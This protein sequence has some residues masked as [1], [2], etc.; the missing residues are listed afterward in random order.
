MNILLESTMN[1]VAML[2]NKVKGLS[3]TNK[4]NEVLPATVEPPTAVILPPAAETQ[5]KISS[6]N[7]DEDVTMDDQTSNSKDADLQDGWNQVIY[8]NSRP[9]TKTRLRKVKAD[10]NNP[11]DNKY[12]LLREEVLSGDDSAEDYPAL[13]LKREKRILKPKV[14][15]IMTNKNLNGDSNKGNSEN[16]GCNAENVTNTVKNH[17]SGRNPPITAYGLNQKNLR[18]EMVKLGTL[19]YRVAGGPNNNRCSIIAHDT[20]TYNNII[21]L[22][23]NDNT[24]F[25]CFTPK[26]ER[27]LNLIIKDVS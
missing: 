25:F 6:P 17:K 22:L 21:K 19:N 14:S 1:V 13:G 4:A 7:V 16:V 12:I 9:N 27:G 24:N 2:D 10:T 15:T 8:K 11:N 23:D 20:E 18:A 3:T 26:G 5:A